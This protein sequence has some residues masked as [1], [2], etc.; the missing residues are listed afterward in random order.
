MASKEFHNPTTVEFVP[1]EK[2]M[3]RTPLPM[4]DTAHFNQ[5]RTMQQKEEYARDLRSRFGQRLSK[6]HIVS[7]SGEH[8]D[9]DFFQEMISKQPIKTS[10]SSNEPTVDGKITSSATREH[11]P[12]EKF[13]DDL[14]K[15]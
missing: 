13:L 11:E 12:L 5:M 15:I 7:S 2:K 9:D 4:E 14:L 1:D 8:D 6:A 3:I 10:K